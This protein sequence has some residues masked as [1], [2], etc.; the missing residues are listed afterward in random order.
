MKHLLLLSALA[1]A[2]LF[3]SSCANNGS[4]ATGSSGNTATAPSG[5]G[6]D[7]SLA[8]TV[9]GKRTVVTPPSTTIYRNEVSHDAAKGSVKIEVTI[10][11]VGEL[12]KFTVA[13][14]GTTDVV[15]FKPSF[16]EEK[17]AATYMSGQGHNYYADHVSITISTVDAAH[18]AGTFSGTF[19]A[20]G[21]TVT[22]T[23][24]SFDLPV[25]DK[26]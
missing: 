22:V 20:E 17:V 24:G 5:N 9:D 6:S 14:K 25:H 15:N 3:G 1:A 8:Y 19:A 18:I 23:D 13:D 11:P 10:F 26:K 2:S 4:A 21:K 12:F 7:G 16:G